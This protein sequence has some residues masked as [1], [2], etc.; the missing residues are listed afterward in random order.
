MGDPEGIGPEVIQ[1]T[2][3]GY[4]PAHPVVILGDSKRFP[5]SHFRKLSRMDVEN[6]TGVFALHVE[7]GGEASF[8]YVKEA[9]KLAREKKV[10]ALVTGPISKK[11]WRDRG[12]GFDGHTDFLARETH[13][14]DYCMF[15]WSEPVKVA[16]FTTHLPLKSIFRHIRKDRIVR[17]MRFLEPELV[18]RFST[19][20]TFFFS[21]LN[22][23]A[24]EDGY[25]GHEEKEEIIPAFEALE[26]EMDIRGVFPPDSVFFNA[27]KTNN[28]VVVCW[29]HDQGLIPFKLLSNRSGVNLTLGLPFIRT[30]PDHGTAP[31][32][33]GKGV[34]NPA[35]MIEAV[36]LAD[37]LI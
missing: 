27:A 22:P 31:E 6:R 9:V 23:H 8:E 1:K 11:K 29:Y 35:S 21:G 3:S 25:L 5:D 30:S 36:K 24:G 7:S 17:F 10:Q 26:A 18:R 19:K 13:T 16:L 20:F 32:I 4:Q 12:I 2:F 34:A 14:R 28:A 37:R 33:A 15:F